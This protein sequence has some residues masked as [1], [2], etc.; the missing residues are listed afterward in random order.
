MDQTPR[1]PPHSLEAEKS[2]LGSMLISRDAAELAAEMLSASDFYVPQ[3][4]D[5]F[6]AMTELVSRAQPVDSV[7]IVDALER[8]GKLASAGGLGYIAELSLFVPSAANVSYYINIVE[9]RSVLRQ[10]IKAG[11]EIMNEASTS[12]SP[13]TDILDEAER[14]VFSISMKKNEETLVPVDK[15]AM[16]AYMRIGELMRT[17]GQI[18]GVPTGFRELDELTSGLQKGDL[19]IVAARPSVGKSTFAMNIA[20]YAA[21]TAGKRVAVFSLEM[22]REQLTTRMLCSQA[23]VDMQKVNSGETTEEDLLVL[24]DALLTLSD[25]KMYIDD[26][27]NLSVADIRSR[28]RRQ[29][30]RYGLDLVVVDYLGLLQLTS[31]RGSLVADIAEAT[32]ALKIL[33]KE[34][35]VPIMLLCQLSRGS[36][37]RKENGYRPILADLRDSGA[38]E[39]D[40][41]LVLLL[42]RKALAM[43][44]RKDDSASGAPNEEIEDNSAEVIVA[45]NR[46]GPLKTVNLAWQGMFARFVDPS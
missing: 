29:K 27:G 11:G 6:E 21:T 43:R 20:E 7:T 45:K 2:V 19:I 28:C 30:T 4:Q 17:R 5:I 24:S 18:S 39:Q 14:R 12:D 33:A 25:S 44:N 31:K 16:A 3:H 41:D 10:L 38:I 15:S 40:A 23:K 9:D 13:V 26:S 22:S 36:E 37:S 46:N 34:L 1:T 42:Y 32:R 35:E 8:A